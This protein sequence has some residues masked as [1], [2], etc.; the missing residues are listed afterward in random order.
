MKPLGMRAARVRWVG[1]QREVI[2]LLALLLAAVAT[3]AFSPPAR[4]P[5]QHVSCQ[6]STCQRSAAWVDT[7]TR[8]V[9]TCVCT[10]L[11]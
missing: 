8:N 6:R 2:L 4:P 11:S 1:R 3:A 9:G 7:A 10:N 5:P